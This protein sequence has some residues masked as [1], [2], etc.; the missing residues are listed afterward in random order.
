MR[1]GQQVTDPQGGTGTVQRFYTQDGL[2]LA[3]VAYAE[4]QWEDQFELDWVITDLQSA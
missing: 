1:T 4:P 2:D 3:T